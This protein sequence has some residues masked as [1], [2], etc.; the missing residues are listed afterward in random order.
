MAAAK[1]TGPAHAPKPPAPSQPATLTLADIWA[2][3]ER[4]KGAVINTDFDHS[5]TLS[6]MFGCE[7]WLKFENLQFTAAF[8]E[9]GALN[10]LSLLTAD[11]RRRGVIAMSAGNHAQGVAYHAK[12]LGIPATIVMPVGTP[13]VKVE[14]TRRHG[15]DVIVTGATL[16]DSA[17]YARAHGETHGLT[18]VHPYDDAA[19]IAGQGTVALEMLTA[20]PAIDTLVVPIGGGG[21]ISGMAVA[22]KA[23]NPKIANMCGAHPGYGGGGHGYSE[24][25]SYGGGGHGHGNYDTHQVY[26]HGYSGHSSYG[27]S[28]YGYSGGHRSHRGIYIDLFGH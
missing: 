11:E 3:A 22:A 10:R 8:K 14:N 19:V 28:G 26:S 1:T 2:A 17:A 20:H 12:R 23:I 27:H 25:H 21:L 9:R 5:R 7:I 15:A 18:F 24:G 16:E 4:V 6:D 13:V